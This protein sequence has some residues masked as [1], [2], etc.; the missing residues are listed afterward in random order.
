ME[1]AKGLLPIY[2]HGGGTV[3]GAASSAWPDAHVL[4]KN[5]TLDIHILHIYTNYGVLH[6]PCMHSAARMTRVDMPCNAK[7]LGQGFQNLLAPKPLL[8]PPS[9]VEEHNYYFSHECLCL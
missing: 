1:Q 7:V 8:N 4:P 3:T 6:T 5:L 9:P 2:M